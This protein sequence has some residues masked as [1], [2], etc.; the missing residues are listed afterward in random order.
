CGQPFLFGYRVGAGGRNVLRAFGTEREDRA[1]R[2]KPLW[3]TWENPPPRSEDRADE[4]DEA[5]GPF[6]AGGY[7]PATG[8]VRHRPCGK[9]RDDEVPLWRVGERA[10]LNRCFA[11]G[12]QDTITPVRADAEAAQAVVADAFYR[13]LPAAPVP[14]AR[15]E[16][17]DY[18]GQ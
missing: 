17:L 9:V 16:A 6:P 13:C 14:P 10:D 3:L 11:C 7:K 5:D 15:R 12:G 8:Q 4:A 1:D 18:P 2:G